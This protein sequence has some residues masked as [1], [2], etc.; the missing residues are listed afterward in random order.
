ML[1]LPLADRSTC[2]QHTQFEL[3]GAS[4]APDPENTQTLPRVKLKL[5]LKLKLLPPTAH[6]E[7]DAKISGSVI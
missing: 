4:H 1:L 6:A 2:M 7:E 5:K 3:R